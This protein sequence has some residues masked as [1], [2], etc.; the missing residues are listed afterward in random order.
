[1]VLTLNE[2][3]AA[4]R[5]I[6]YPVAVKPVTGHKGIGVT[7]NVKDEEELEAAFDRAVQAIEE[8]HSVRV[9]VETSIS[10]K[11][12]RM[13]C[14]NGKFVAATERRPAFVVGDGHSTIAELIDR[15]NR[16]AARTDTPTS[17]LGK[18]K[19]D[20]AMDLYLE[21]QGLSLDSVV[22]PDRTVYLRK[23]ANLSSGGFSIDATASVHPDNIILAQDIAQH[24]RLTCLGIDVVASD[25]STSWK[26]GSFG[27]IEINSAPGIF[28]HLKPAI[29]DRIDVTSHILD[30]F[31]ESAESARVPIITFNRISTSELQELIDYILLRCPNFVVGAVCRDAVFI[32]RSEKV[33]HPNHNTNVLNL[34][35]HPKLDLLITEYRHEVLDK[36][37]MFYYGSNVVV[38]NNP[39]EVEM[40]L[41][42]DVFNNSIV[43]TK[44]Q[45][46]VS[47]Q[48]Q[49]LIEQYQL[50]PDEPFSR[51][52]LKEVAALL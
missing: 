14:V 34:L 9:I 6:G 36:Q 12:F 50:R 18:I 33:L 7:A 44:Q 17:P 8:D 26:E 25:L 27:I 28:M 15:E 45:D 24:F 4:A 2:A 41:A 46:N 40:M 35:R 1:V 30:T 23:V 22:A 19:I 43:V 38:L 5:R 29:G 42:R 16:S 37:G 32:N 49:G 10:G 39:S 51:V 20:E 48:R 52:F 11:D 47:I 13:L 31:F 3:L 21:Q